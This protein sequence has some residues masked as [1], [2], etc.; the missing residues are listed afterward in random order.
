MQKAK[1]PIEKEIQK[2][3]VRVFT[4]ESQLGKTDSLTKLKSKR[5]ASGCGEQSKSYRH[6]KQS[7]C[8]LNIPDLEQSKCVLKFPRDTTSW[9]IPWYDVR[10]IGVWGNNYERY[11][12]LKRLGTRIKIF[13]DLARRAEKGYIFTK[14]KSKNEKPNIR[15]LYLL[16]SPN[17][18]YFH[19]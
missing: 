2:G 16:L 12:W 9:T 4:Y 15:G 3:K 6:L 7:K 8:V 14:E 11:L 17:V 18:L 1:K 13:K 19:L 5:F 10:N